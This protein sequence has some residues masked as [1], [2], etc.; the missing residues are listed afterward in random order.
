M[1]EQNLMGLMNT[2]RFR[3]SQYVDKTLTISS[4]SNVESTH[5]LTRYWAIT[6]E[7][8]MTTR[9]SNCTNLIGPYPKASTIGSCKH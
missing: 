5:R 3:I 7:R 9:S 2:I 1:V 8:T 4:N 6:Q